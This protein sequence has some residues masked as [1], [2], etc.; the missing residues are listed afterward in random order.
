MKCLFTEK[1]ILCKDNLQVNIKKG[2]EKINTNYNKHSNRRNLVVLFL[3]VASIFGGI[4]KNWFFL[5]AS[6]THHP[7]QMLGC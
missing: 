6:F 5:N 7:Q 1:V 2:Y 3:F 4:E